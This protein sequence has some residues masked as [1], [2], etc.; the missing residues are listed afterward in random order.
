MC[1][2]FKHN[3]LEV[4]LNRVS[5]T[6]MYTQ[7]MYLGTSVYTPLLL[8]LSFLLVWII[9]RT[10][11]DDR[12]CSNAPGP[13]A[14]P[15]LGNLPSLG[16]KP[17]VYL[18]ELRK[19]YG[20]VYQIMM[21]SRPT[22][23]IN[24]LTAIRKATV[25]KAEDFAGRPDFYTFK[26]LANGK[27]MGFS[28][29]GPRWKLHRKIAQ[30]SLSSFTNK[31]NSP[32]EQAIISEAELLTNNM[33]SSKGKPVNPHNE[34]YLS[35]GNIICAL[36]FGQRYQRDDE[37]FVFL[38][39]MNDKFMAT[40]GAGNPVDIMPW[41]RHFTKRSFNTFLGILKTMDN[42]S[43]KKRQE[44]LDTYNPANL[45]DVTDALIRAT[46]EIPEEAKSAVGLTDEHILLTV[47]ELIGAGFDT[48]ASTLQWSVL[49]MVTHP[50]IQEKVH[51]EIR[52]YVGMD[53]YPEFEDLEH[54][55][56][57]E[58]TIIETMRHSCIFPFALPH[59]TT[60]DTVL[61]DYFIPENTLIFLNLWSVNHDPEV[62]PDPQKFN[63]YRF[64]GEDKKS[65]NKVDLF[66]PFGAGR[67]K[68][69]GEQLAHMEL[70][71]FFATMLQRCKFSVVP[72]KV[73]VIDSKYGLTLKPLDFD[74]LVE[75]R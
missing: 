42:F 52:A 75:H 38:V 23:V 58:S 15:V 21:G 60:K 4:N 46:E 13:M 26:F 73:P 6:G 3:Q 2:K 41:M 55:P 66:L 65:V 43:L 29:Y 16:K 12:K 19:K 17:H 48:I 7:Y 72:G 27:S 18:T 34:I 30:N 40:M 14:W 56:F 49:F 67:R 1:I 68:C 35:V 8:A 51:Q 24:G 45:R 20:D 54:L 61:N 62:F 36:C 71:I 10:K 32:I 57:T 44:H 63:P 9:Y 53:R 28:D 25:N 39:K 11:K 50:E 31:R 37:D 64:L 33:L 47:Q 74:V 59:S 5:L 70:F 69:P 22:I